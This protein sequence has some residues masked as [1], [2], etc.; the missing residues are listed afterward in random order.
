MS[1][2][3]E[4][5]YCKLNP[6]SAVRDKG[7]GYG[8]IKEQSLDFSCRQQ[9][10][11]DIRIVIRPAVTFKT[12]FNIYYSSNRLLLERFFEGLPASSSV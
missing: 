11:A 9:S 12:Q 6:H 1:L 3:E 4:S 7:R 5:K 2:P 8:Q 10:P